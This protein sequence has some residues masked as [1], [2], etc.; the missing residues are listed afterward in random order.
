MYGTTGAV[1]NIDGAYFM[2]YAQFS[3]WAA[4]RRLKN[5][6]QSR[7]GRVLGN[8][9]DFVLACSL[10]ERKKVCGLDSLIDSSRGGLSA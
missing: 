2:A 8:H 7:L 3:H 9:H 4:V 10:A 5:I 1:G 6:M